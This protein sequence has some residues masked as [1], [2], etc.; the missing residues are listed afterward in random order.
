MRKALLLLVAVLALLICALPAMADYKPPV[1]PLEISVCCDFDVVIEEIA[2]FDIECDLCDIILD[3]QCD[4]GPWYNI[5]CVTYFVSTN[6]PWAFTGYWVNGADLEDED[7]EE[8]LEFPEDWDLWWVLGVDQD[9]EDF[10]VLPLEDEGA[11]VFDEDECG[12]FTGFVCFGLTGPD[13]CDP[14]GVYNSVLCF[15]LGP[16]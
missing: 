3:E 5:G 2:E 10:E 14:P 11:V 7:P 13:I 12:E 1:D 16:V 4:F 9:I 6:M 8:I 15:F